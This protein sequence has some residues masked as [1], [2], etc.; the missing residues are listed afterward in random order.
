[1]QR[2]PEPEPEN[3][4]LELDD[5]P[6]TKKGGI[7]F[8][9]AIFQNMGGIIMP[10]HRPNKGE[11]KWD[12]HKD[13]FLMDFE[14][15]CFEHDWHGEPPKGKSRHLDKEWAKMIKRHVYPSHSGVDF[16]E[17]VEWV[18]RGGGDEWFLKEF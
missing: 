1:M 7:D 15:F 14:N 10:P 16:Y 18:E 5:Y 6:Q 9:K 17:Y 2:E 8:V 11:F 12:L 13:N 4:S 3:M